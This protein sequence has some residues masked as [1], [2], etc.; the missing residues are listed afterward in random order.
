MTPHS[1]EKL[2]FSTIDELVT[3]LKLAATPVL[4][5]H[6]N[7]TPEGYPFFVVVVLAEPGNEAAV[8]LAREF[9]DKMAAQASWS[10]RV[11]NPEAKS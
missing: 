4:A 10:V 7:T 11:D 3:A 8:G 2:R 1:W 5:L 6:G 9:H